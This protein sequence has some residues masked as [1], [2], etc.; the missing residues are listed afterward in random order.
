V[1][2]PNCPPEGSDSPL[3]FFP[4]REAYQLV[5]L[6]TSSDIGRPVRRTRGLKMHTMSLN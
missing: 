4:S 5:M 1:I 3:C 2:S 6:I